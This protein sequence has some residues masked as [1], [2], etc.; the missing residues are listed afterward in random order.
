MKDNKWEYFPNE[1]EDD[2]PHAHSTAK[3]IAKDDFVVLKD[4][5]AERFS[6][7]RSKRRTRYE[8]EEAREERWN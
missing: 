4:V 1:E 3:R 8:H 7:R 6:E 5:A 2:E